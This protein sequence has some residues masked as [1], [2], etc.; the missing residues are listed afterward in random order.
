MVTTQGTSLNPN[1]QVWQEVPVLQTDAL[2]VTEDSAWISTYPPPIDFVEDYSEFP[3]PD[4]KDFGLVYPDGSDYGS[5]YD[6]AA[7][8]VMGGTCDYPD[9]AYLVFEPPYNG[10]VEEEVMADKTLSE[11]NLRESLKKQLE[12]YFSRENLSKDL[13]LISQ[14]DS[15]QFV[16][17]WTIACMEDIK[18]LTSDLELIVDVLKTSPLVQVD[19]SGEKVRPNYS[20]CIIILREVPETTPVEEVEALFNNENCP[21]TLSAEFA[22]NSNWYITFQSDNDALQALKYL[23][24]EVKIFQGKPI[25]ARIKAINTFFGKSGFHSV[26]SSVFS[27]PAPPPQTPQ[28]FGSPVY[29]DM[30]QVYS[31]Q[32]QYPVYPVVSPSWSPTPVPYF[33]TP[34]AP[35]QNS[36][37]MNGYRGSGNYKGNSLSVNGHGPRSRNQGYAGSGCLMDVAP[38]AQISGAPIRPPSDAL[39][40][41]SFH[42]KDSSLLP[43]VHNGDGRPRRPNH[44]GMRRKK[45]DDVNA[46]PHPTAEVKPP[47]PNFDLAACNFPPLPGSVVTAKEETALDVCMAD[48]VRGLKVSD[49]TGSQEFKE[50]KPTDQPDDVQSKPVSPSLPT[51]EVEPA[52]SCSSSESHK[53][54]T[55]VDTQVSNLL[56]ETSVSEEPQ[57][58]TS[59]SATTVSAPSAPSPTSEPEPKKLSYAEVCQRLAKDP[60]SIQPSPPYPSSPPSPPAPQPNQPLQELKV[61]RVQE[62]RNHPN[63]H[64]SEKPR[65]HQHPRHFRGSHDADRPAPKNRDRPRNF[66]KSFSAQRGSKRSG[67]EQNIPPSPK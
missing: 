29:I 67:K 21:K 15:D 8:E 44:R 53:D 6:P 61:N 39:S 55:E 22:H 51:P 11:E 20:R 42:P 24:E 65:N 10:T 2:E 64:N 33:E 63:K 16:P 48:V 13:Y 7:P 58:T 49:K 9:L 5:D 40:P 54:D 23:R 17:I 18:S 36:G 19:E 26:D 47:P 31:P 12:F 14:M 35:F 30:Q 52:T 25:M 28:P 56:S 3:S 34:L 37:Y 43:P 32:P 62:P 45:E 38:Q 50:S 4:G 46:K 27:Q 66:N 1:A 41:T 57:T 60:P 59:Q